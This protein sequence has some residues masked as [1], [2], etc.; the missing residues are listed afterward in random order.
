MEQTLS[1]WDLTILDKTE[2]D[3]YVRVIFAESELARKNAVKVCRAAG[4]DVDGLK[5][6]VQVFKRWNEFADVRVLTFSKEKLFLDSPKAASKQAGVSG[7]V[8]MHMTL[9]EAGVH[10]R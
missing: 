6:D 2:T 9:Q 10:A 8:P 4:I 5:R 7:S 1:Q 3:R